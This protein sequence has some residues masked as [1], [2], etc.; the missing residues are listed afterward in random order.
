MHSAEKGNCAFGMPSISF[1][2]SELCITHKFTFGKRRE[3]HW[4][5]K[6]RRSDTLP[7]KLNLQS[8]RAFPMPVGSRTRDCANASCE[9][10]LR[11]PFTARIRPTGQSQ[12]AVSRD[13][14][15]LAPSEIRKPSEGSMFP[16]RFGIVRWIGR[17]GDSECVPATNQ[18]SHAPDAIT[19]RGPNS[20]GPSNAW[21]WLPRLPF[22]RTIN[23]VKPVDDGGAPGSSSRNARA[24]SRRDWQ[25]I[26][27]RKFIN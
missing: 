20:R 25:E 6:Y 13:R 7:A 1:P 3:L 9:R 15:T 10:R 2:S 26:T 18:S 23:P 12:S 11:L 4:K 17:S 24:I 5:C 21:D 27:E 22:T 8:L 16:R 19:A 14:P